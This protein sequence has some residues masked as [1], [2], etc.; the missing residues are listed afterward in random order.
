MKLE[1]KFLVLKIA[2]IEEALTSPQK[3]LLQMYATRVEEWRLNH[4]KH[5]HSYVV[6]NRDEPYFP[7]VLKLMEGDPS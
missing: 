6:I 3:R 2:D 4:G 5:I 7:A 1:Q